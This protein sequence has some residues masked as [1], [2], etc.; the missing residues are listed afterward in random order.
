MSKELDHL[1][2][3]RKS[4]YPQKPKN[5]RP[6]SVEKLILGG[7]VLFIIIIVYNQFRPSIPKLEGGTKEL[8]ELQREGCI[9]S[10]KHFEQRQILHI[11]LTQKGKSKLKGKVSEKVSEDEPDFQLYVDKNFA[12]N[13]T[14]L[15]KDRL[16]QPQFCMLEAQEP[17]YLDLV[18]KSGVLSMLLYLFLFFALWHFFLS[19]LMGGS[20]RTTPGTVFNKRV[21]PTITLQDVKGMEEAKKQLRDIV[22]YF[23]YPRKYAAIGAVPPKGA[24]LIGPPGTGKTLLARAIAGEAGVNFISS[25]RW[26]I[27]RNVCRLRSQTNKKALCRC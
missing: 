23:K 8:F 10:I 21:G 7:V 18:S 15:Y 12:K 22:D 6:N 17:D 11:H 9:K 1:S 19:D 24:I 14:E 3:N 13:Y 2:Q 26:R 20:L 4:G 27:R 25:L 16:L 5:S